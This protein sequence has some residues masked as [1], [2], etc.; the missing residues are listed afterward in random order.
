LCYAKK[1]KDNFLGSYILKKWL[2]YGAMQ[3]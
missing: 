2:N 1:N 3:F